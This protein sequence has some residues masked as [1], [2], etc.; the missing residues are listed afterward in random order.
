M[1]V[2]A[3]KEGQIEL[4]VQTT[5]VK[6]L[7]VKWVRDRPEGKELCYVLIENRRDQNL[8]KC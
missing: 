2:V 3:W 8:C 1:A 5:L 6:S 7:A 4:Q